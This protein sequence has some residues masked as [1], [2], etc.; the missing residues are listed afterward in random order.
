MPDA[1]V[2]EIAKVVEK[3]LNRT[4]AAG[5]APDGT[6]WKLRKDGGKPLQNA[7][8]AIAVGAVGNTIIIRLRGR[9]NVLHHFGYARGGIERQI[10]PTEITAEMRRII[11]KA[12]EKVAL[13]HGLS[14]GAS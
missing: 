10:I 1:A 7:R 14:G 12:I 3:D 4:L 13:A 11:N 5:Q 2:K 9:S 6:P 8:N